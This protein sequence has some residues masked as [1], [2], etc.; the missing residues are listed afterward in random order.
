MSVPVDLAALAAEIARFGEVAFLV[1]TAPGTRPHVVSVRVASTDG[2]LT[3]S[4]G[5]T[6]RAN[7]AGA[8]EVALCWP[9]APDGEYCLLVDGRAVVD[10]VAET[11]RVTPTAAILHRLAGAST[12]LPYCAPVD[13]APES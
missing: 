9:G 4:A 6:S 2:V 1:T 10:D 8:P 13:G 7:A 12:D 5:R 3:M 11:V